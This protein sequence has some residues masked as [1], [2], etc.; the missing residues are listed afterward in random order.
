L[1]GQDFNRFCEGQTVLV[2]TTSKRH[3]LQE[4]PTTFRTWT[5]KS[6]MTPDELGT[7]SNMTPHELGTETNMTPFEHGMESNLTP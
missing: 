5:G 4:E 7:G 3:R 1:F 6:N 2:K